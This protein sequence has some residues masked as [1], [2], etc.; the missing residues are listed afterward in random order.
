M[1]VQDTKNERKTD[2]EFRMPVAEMY[3]QLTPEEQAEAEYFLTKYFE[4]L[5]AIFEEEND[6][7]GSDL[8]ARV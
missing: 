3:P 4:V 5:N 1:H 6:L 2:P 7:T 8:N